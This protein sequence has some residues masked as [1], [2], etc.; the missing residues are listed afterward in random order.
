[1]PAACTESHLPAARGSAAHGLAALLLLLLLGCL[2]SPA[3]RALSE[4]VILF[5]YFKDP[6]T[7]GI[8]LMASEDGLRFEHLNGGAPILT[9]PGGVTRDP[10]IV[11]GPDDLFHMV[12]TAAPKSFGY[13]SS[14]DLVTWS[15]PRLIP[16]FG[17]DDPIVNTWAPEL[18]YDTAAQEYLVVWASTDR[19]RF[20]VGSNE[21][22]LYE[23][24]LYATTTRDFASFTETRL[25]YDP[26]F[27]VI[28]GMIAHDVA[29]DRFVMAIKDERARPV[30]Q[31]NI[32][33]TFSDSAQG[34]YGPPSDSVTG[35]GLVVAE[36][37]EGPTLLPID[38]GWRLYFDSY[39]DFD[40]VYHAYESPDL[41]TWIDVTDQ[42]VFPAID[43]L[44][45]HGTVFR[46]ERR[47]VGWLVPEPATGLML[48][49]GIVALAARRSSHR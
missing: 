9:V 3:A 5:P 20:P 39:T 37:A 42:L 11:R 41:E 35:G 26:G 31:K 15:V 17:P 8:F 28:D 22:R 49:A 47:N 44:L 40:S 23:H 34:P 45:Q 6:G 1:M 30:P 38:D 27:N 7:Q 21:D 46:S 33:L 4:D 19:E 18:F 12:W 43:G 24:R 48:A 29:G 25:F 16:V 32:K 13:A 36:W 2:A 14:P 10:S